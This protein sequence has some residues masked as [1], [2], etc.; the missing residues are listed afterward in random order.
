M[1]V[2][3]I[4]AGIFLVALTSA[5]AFGQV[6]NLQAERMLLDDDATDGGFN[7]LT[8]QV[9]VPGLTLDRI[10]VFPDADGTL[11]ASAAPL[12]PNQVLFGGLTG[13]AAQSADFLWD[14]ATSTL[15]LNQAGSAD[16][17]Q[18]SHSGADGYAIFIDQTN[19]ANTEHVI[20]IDAVG[21]GNA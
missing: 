3:T 21:D 20:G 8:L 2:R 17:L 4:V 13:D 9:P 5:T 18:I 12:T 7:T 16:A 14:N 11:L 19:A 1:Y 10:L 15:A 6:R